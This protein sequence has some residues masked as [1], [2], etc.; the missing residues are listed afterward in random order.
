M[1]EHLIV[2]GALMTFVG[3]IIAMRMQGAAR[4]EQA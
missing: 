3:A 1:L 2:S 4:E